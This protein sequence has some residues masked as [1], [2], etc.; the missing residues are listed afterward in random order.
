MVRLI[1]DE[2]LIRPE[3]IKPSSNAFEVL[4]VLNPAAIRLPN[5]KILLYVRVM[6]KLKKVEDLILLVEDNLIG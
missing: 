2:I 5:G 3:N 6:E 1:K 4:C